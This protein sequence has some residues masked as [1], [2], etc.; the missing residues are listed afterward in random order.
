MVVSLLATVLYARERKA[1][2]RDADRVGETIGIDRR[3]AVWAGIVEFG[4]LG[5]VACIPGVVAAI[6]VSARIAPTFERFSPFPPDIELS[7]PG[8]AVA[9]LATQSF[10]SVVAIGAL[11][12]GRTKGDAGGA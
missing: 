12:E 2:R 6:A 9:L 10:L 11:I 1:A 4:L 3:T 8:V 5:I 7:V